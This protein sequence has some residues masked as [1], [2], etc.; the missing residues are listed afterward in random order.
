MLQ[1]DS[2]KFSSRMED[3]ERIL[4]ATISIN[5]SKELQLFL[6]QHGDSWP[7]L[8]PH[9][10]MPPKY[11]ISL[12]QLQ[13]NIIKAAKYLLNNFKENNNKF[14]D[15]SVVGAGHRGL[16]NLQYPVYAYSFPL[17]ALSRLS[18][19]IKGEYKH[20]VNKEMN[21]RIEKYLKLSNQQNNDLWK[22]MK[23]L[24]AI[25]IHL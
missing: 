2:R 24:W 6:W 10:Q 16:L 18:K 17:V 15:R 23:Q 13:T 21:A 14:F 12:F 1:R 9:I 3:S 11:S 4:K 25:I 20:Y 8:M 19:L 5:I 22:S 7:T